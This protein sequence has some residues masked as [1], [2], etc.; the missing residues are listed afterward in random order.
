[1]LIMLVF[2]G[3]LQHVQH[4]EFQRSQLLR[5]ESSVLVTALLARL[6]HHATT[7]TS[8]PKAC[9]SSSA[10]RGGSPSTPPR[11]DTM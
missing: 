8:A 4:R 1:M 9:A 10:G 2:T 11:E 7:S 5:L 6:L 3:R